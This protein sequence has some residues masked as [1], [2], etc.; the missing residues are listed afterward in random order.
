MTRIMTTGVYAIPKAECNA[1][2]V[3]TNTNATVAYRGAGRPEAAA[4]IERAVDLFAAEIGVDPVEV[5]RRHPAAP[6]VPAAPEPAH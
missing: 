3:V 1:K 4:A 6:R 2:S 5:R